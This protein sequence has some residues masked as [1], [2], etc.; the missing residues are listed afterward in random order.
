MS[1]SHVIRGKLREIITII[2]VL[3]LM[4]SVSFSA[5]AAASASDLVVR[6]D[7]TAGVGLF[8][9]F[10]HH[11]TQRADA[12]TDK[13]KDTKS[14]GKHHC[15]CCLA[16]QAAAAVLPERL[17][18]FAAPVAS[19]TRVDYLADASDAPRLVPDRR[20]NGARA[21]PV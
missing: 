2:A 19:S 21:P 16:A 11:M 1:Q 3:S 17:P 18:I 14:A 12:T 15:P 10:K 13:T 9:C 6:S 20:A 4:F 7:G 8:A 5:A